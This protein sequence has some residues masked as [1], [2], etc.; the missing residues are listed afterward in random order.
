MYLKQD[1]VTLLGTSFAGAK[2]PKVTCA[3]TLNDRTK[4]IITGL[5]YTHSLLTVRMVRLLPPKDGPLLARA[6]RQRFRPT[7]TAEAL[8]GNARTNATQRVDRNVRVLQDP[9][10]DNR[11]HRDIQLA[12]NDHL[13]H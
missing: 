9:I 3:G 5:N 11:R 1:Y 4:N 12:N 2:L 6:H 7:E 8:A 13:A 10:H